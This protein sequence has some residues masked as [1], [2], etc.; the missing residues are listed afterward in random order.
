MKTLL[1]G[2]GRRQNQEKISMLLF[3]RK[4]KM[5][6]ILIF[7]S[8]AN[9]VL[10]LRNLTCLPAEVKGIIIL[11]D[12]LISAAYWAKVSLLCPNQE[13]GTAVES[14]QSGTLSLHEQCL[15]G[16]DENTF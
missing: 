1:H 9:Q 12:Q 6:A 10:I 5:C 7:I 16:H 11:W 8:E 13:G 14:S 4:K 3:E 2:Q 15:F